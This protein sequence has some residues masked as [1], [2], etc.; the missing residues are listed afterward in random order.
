LIEYKRFFPQKNTLGSTL[1]EKGVVCDSE[2][3]SKIGSSKN[4]EKS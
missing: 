2:K 3:S 1:E 4:E